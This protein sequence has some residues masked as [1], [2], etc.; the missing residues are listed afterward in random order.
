MIY[1]IIIRKKI[2]NNLLLIYLVIIM[3][4]FKNYNLPLLTYG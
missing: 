1:H 4:L 3:K 2:T